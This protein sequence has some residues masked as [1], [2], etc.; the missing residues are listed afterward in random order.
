[1]SAMERFYTTVSDALTGGLGQND[2]NAAEERRK[3]EER[4]EEE[5]RQAE[6]KD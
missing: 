2:D 3:E 4:R 5:A 1:M 6:K